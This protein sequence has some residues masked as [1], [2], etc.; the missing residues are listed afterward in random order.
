VTVE[1]VAQAARNEMLR[2]KCI[3]RCTFDVDE[4]SVVRNMYERAYVTQSARERG[5]DLTPH[6]RESETGNSLHKHI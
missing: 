6:S 4:I 2:G 5:F 1:V 3:V